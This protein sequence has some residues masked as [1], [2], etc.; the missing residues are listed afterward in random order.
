MIEDTN[1]TI[2]TDFKVD[3]LYFARINLRSILYN[4]LS[5][6]IKYRSPERNPEIKISTSQKDRYIV[7]TIQDNGLGLNENQQKRLFTMFKRF[8]TH[9]DGTGIGLYIVKRIVENKEGKIEVGSKKG[10]GTTF[11]IYFLN[12]QKKYEQEL[13]A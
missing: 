2:I 13:I 10:E 8:H 4:L 5:N 7:L 11:K 1:T 3:H 12:E 6:A 9:V